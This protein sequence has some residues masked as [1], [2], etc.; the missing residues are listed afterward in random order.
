M[1]SNVPPAQYILGPFGEDRDLR[2]H[3]LK[4]A[5]RGGR[6]AKKNA[7]VAIARKLSVIMHTLWSNP[8][9]YQ[10]LRTIELDETS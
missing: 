5:E 6:S 2:R 10:A 3:G 1:I 7:V 9:D 8:S 4:L